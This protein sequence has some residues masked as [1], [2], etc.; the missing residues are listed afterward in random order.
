M[1]V[2]I[3]LSQHNFLR[4][5]EEQAVPTLLMHQHIHNT[6][7]LHRL[8]HTQQLELLTFGKEATTEIYPSAYFPQQAGL[9]LLFKC[10]VTLC[11]THHTLCGIISLTITAHM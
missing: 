7:I 2:A 5:L 11:T 4:K 10:R 1:G 6:N 9:Y 8:A 3:I